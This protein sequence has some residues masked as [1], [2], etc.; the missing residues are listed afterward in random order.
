MSQRDCYLNNY[1]TLN[2][3]SNSKRNYNE[4]YDKGIKRFSF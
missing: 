3:S 4:I 2:A 1:P